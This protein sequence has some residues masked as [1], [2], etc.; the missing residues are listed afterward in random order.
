[1]SPL[2]AQAPSPSLQRT[3]AAD[4]TSADD[5]LTVVSAAFSAGPVTRTELLAAAVAQR[6]PTFVLDAL[7]RLPERTYTDVFDLRSQ[8]FSI[9]T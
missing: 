9:K 1:M 2:S 6:A 7:L 5:V 4:S 3:A 8:F